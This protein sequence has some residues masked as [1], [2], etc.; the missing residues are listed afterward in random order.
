MPLFERSG[1]YRIFS[2]VHQTQTRGK[3]KLIKSH[4]FCVCVCAGLCS[5][6][7]KNQFSFC[8]YIA[9]RAHPSI[10]THEF[11]IVDVFLLTRMSRRQSQCCV[12]HFDHY[13]HFFVVLCLVCS[14]PSF[15]FPSPIQT[16]SHRKL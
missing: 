4:G 9:P 15:G 1:Q 12:Q 3:K 7:K 11:E 16:V 13:E 6:D 2:F 5:V 8:F 10:E 14:I